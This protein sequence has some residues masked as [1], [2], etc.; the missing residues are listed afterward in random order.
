MTYNPRCM[1]NH[2]M[3]LDLPLILE[4]RRNH[5]LEHATLHVLARKYQNHH[6]RAFQPDGLFSA[7][8]SPTQDIA[9]CCHEAMTRL[10]A[11][12][13]NWRSMRA[14]APTWRPLRFSPGP[15]AG[16]RFEEPNP[17]FG[18]SGSFRLRW[19][20]PLFGY[21]FSK[22]LGPWLQ[23]IHHHRSGPGRHEDHQIF[24]SSAKTFIAL[25]P[26]EFGR[27]TPRP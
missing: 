9:T 20:S 17:P 16:R 2:R 3:L 15:L 19:S 14:A 12:K 10:T 27:G 7:R 13:A 21:L 1:Y 24:I 6:G 4:T 23:T 8:K 11:V 22:P 5:A 18:E 26:N 25:L